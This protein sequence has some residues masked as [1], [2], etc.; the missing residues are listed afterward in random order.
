MNMKLNVEEATAVLFL[1]SEKTGSC[2]T[3]SDY[4]VD[5]GYGD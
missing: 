2:I 1:A 3:G 5:G 4:C